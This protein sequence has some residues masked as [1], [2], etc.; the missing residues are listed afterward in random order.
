MVY[1]L[2][3]FYIN[4]PAVKIYHAHNMFLNYAAETGVIGFFAFFTYF[5]GSIR[6]AWKRMGQAASDFLRALRLGLG[7]ALVSVAVCGLTDH[8]AFNIP[9]SMLLWALCALCA[10]TARLES[11]QPVRVI[12]EMNEAVADGEETAD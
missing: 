3:D 5:F 12:E 9:T 7:L 10:V 4:D 2:Y 6:L 11:D 8:V 1:P